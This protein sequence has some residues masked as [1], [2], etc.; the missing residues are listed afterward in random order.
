MSTADEQ[1]AEV[2][3]PDPHEVLADQIAAFATSMA[4]N[5]HDPQ[6]LGTLGRLFARSVGPVL[7]DIETLD[8]ADTR[9]RTQEILDAI[10]VPEGA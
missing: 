5:R 10:F 7:R 2:E 4:A 8:A 9:A 6:M 3:Q 1:D